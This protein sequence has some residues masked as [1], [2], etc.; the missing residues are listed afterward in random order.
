MAI[1]RVAEDRCA[2]SE[3]TLVY[4]GG[5][6]N[7]GWDM[8]GRR[9]ATMQGT[10]YRDLAYSRC[11]FAVASRKLRTHDCKPVRIAHGT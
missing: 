5:L 10:R 4:F 3:R 9:D 2:K 7:V 8:L 11:Q 1:G 6:A